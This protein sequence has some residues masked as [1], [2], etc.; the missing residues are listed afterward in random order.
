[1]STTSVGSRPLES[2]ND[3]RCLRGEFSGG[4]S[5]EF[6]LAVVLDGLEAAAART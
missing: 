3:D 2:P 1:L 4:Q 5:F 6:G